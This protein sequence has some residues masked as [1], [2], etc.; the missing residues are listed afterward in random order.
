MTDVRLSGRS[1]AEDERAP[2]EEIARRHLD[3][4]YSLAVREVGDRELA[5]DVSQ[6]VFVVLARKQQSLREGTVLT[7]GLFKTT[8][9]CAADALRRERRRQ[10][11]EHKAAAMAHRNVGNDAARVELDDVRPLLSS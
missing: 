5:E 9:Y 3:L 6:A 1:V 2:I 11:Y 7:G 4:V 8:R 10:H